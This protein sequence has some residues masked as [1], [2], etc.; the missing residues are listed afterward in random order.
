MGGEFENLAII[1]MV[2]YGFSLLKIKIILNYY[3]KK[4]LYCY[5]GLLRKE[6]IEY[7]PYLL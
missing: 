5:V 2:L 3:A 4:K 7:F 1:S 6:R